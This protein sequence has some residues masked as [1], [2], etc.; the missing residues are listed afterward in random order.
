[1]TLLTNNSRMDYVGNGSTAAYPF[2]FWVNLTTDLVVTIADLSTPPVQ[3]TLQLG[4]D[5]NVTG[6]LSPTGGDVNLETYGQSWMTGSN[7]KTGYHLTIQRVVAEEQQTDI[8]NQGSFYPETYESALDYLT[9]QVQQLQ[10]QL[11]RAVMTPVTLPPAAFSP[12]I[13]EGIQTPGSVLMTNSA[14]D[15]FVA[16][17]VSLSAATEVQEIPGGLVNGVNT[18]FT[19][20][21]TPISSASVKIYV[22]GLLLRQGIEYSISGS[23]ITLTN[24]LQIG[25]RI[26]ADYY[27]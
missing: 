22:D 14:G 15:G 17:A 8:R 18:V 24:A 25:R 19:L 1:M 26:Y 2:T 6:L 12:A 5:Y 23:T 20:A 27:H 4:V 9:M 13:P 16:V 21:N 3:T 10:E 11:N 7:L